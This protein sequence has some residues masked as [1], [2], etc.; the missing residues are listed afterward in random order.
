[1]TERY[2]SPNPGLS[3]THLG[4]SSG[5]AT[6]LVQWGGEYVP[7]FSRIRDPANQTRYTKANAPLRCTF[8]SLFSG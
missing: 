3:S 6:G 2:P 1:M 4:E 8:G 7:L 5:I